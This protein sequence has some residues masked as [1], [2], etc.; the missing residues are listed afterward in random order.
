MLSYHW[1]VNGSEYT[2]DLVE[3]PGTNGEPY[4]FG[5][6][7]NRRPVEVAPF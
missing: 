1:K 6:G 3:V 4:L 7:L 2:L 5:R